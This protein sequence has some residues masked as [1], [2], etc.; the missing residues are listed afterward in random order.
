MTVAAASILRM[1]PQTQ[2]TRCGYPDCA[3]YAMAVAD[4]VADSNQCLPGGSEGVERLA[5]RTGPP[6]KPLNPDSGQQ[7]PRKVYHLSLI[8]I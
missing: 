3:A 5:R 2:C 1:L 4:G 7:C 6:G 8:H